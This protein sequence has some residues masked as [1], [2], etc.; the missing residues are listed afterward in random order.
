[1]SV[2]KPVELKKE[3][4]TRLEIFQEALDKEVARLR[5]WYFKCTQCRSGKPV[6]LLCGDRLKKI[7]HMDS[8]PLSADELP[9]NVGDF[10]KGFIKEEYVHSY[11]QFGF[12]KIDG[13][14]PSGIKCIV[15]TVDGSDVVSCRWDMSDNY[16]N[17]YKNGKTGTAK[18]LHEHLQAYVYEKTDFDDYFFMSKALFVYEDK[19]RGMLDAYSSTVDANIPSTDDPK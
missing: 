16:F 17:F 12:I 7:K 2:N 4:K 13:E 6:Y 19:S 9:L 10:I 1:M 15:A 3:N 11:E 8:K 18:R 14:F 5:N